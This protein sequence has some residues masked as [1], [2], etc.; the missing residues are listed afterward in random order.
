MQYLYNTLTTILG[1]VIILI[2]NGDRIN[3]QADGKEM[4]EYRKSSTLS[5][6]NRRFDLNDSRITACLARWI[7]LKISADD[8]SP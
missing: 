8:A 7:K 1:L 4:T 6:L 2:G 5:N 3:H